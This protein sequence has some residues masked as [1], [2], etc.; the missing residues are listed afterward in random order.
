MD[1]LKKIIMRDPFYVV[2]F[3]CICI[4][5]ISGVWVSKSN[6]DIAKKFNEESDS[7]E[8]IELNLEK[9]PIE[10]KADIEKEQVQKEETEQEVAKQKTEE[11]EQSNQAQNKVA[12]NNIQSQAQAQ[13][14]TQA[15][16]SD[17][18]EQSAIAMNHPVKG[19]I[20]ID[21]A[22]DKLV[23]SKTLEQWTTHSG[24]DIQASEGTAVL[25][26]MDGTIKEI[27]KDD[28][29]GIVITIDHGNGLETKYGN[30]ATDDM[31]KKGQSIKKVVL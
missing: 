14:Q 9:A 22:K 11:V 24:I 10:K 23:Y 20:S 12:Q 1:R 21:F 19:N 28:A 5:A 29:L 26:A 6:L 2:L 15:A 30:L 31:I 7:K 3:V 25:A 16:S 18:T 4:V 8:E 13:P 17:I 27:K